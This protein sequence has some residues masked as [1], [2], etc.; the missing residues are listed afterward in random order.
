M[1]ELCCFLFS[2]VSV[3]LYNSQVMLRGNETN[4]YVIASAAKT[5]LLSCDH[6]P[7][8]S[9]QQLMSKTTLVGSIDCMQVFNI[10]A[11]SRLHRLYAGTTW[12]YSVF[13]QYRGSIDCMQGYIHYFY[14]MSYCY[15]MGFTI[16]HIVYTKV[17]ASLLHR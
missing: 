5:S 14:C 8:W 10:F 15:L 6:K 7:I 12:L 4:G 16:Y 3:E 1:L 17:K 2:I 9:S 13:L 11:V